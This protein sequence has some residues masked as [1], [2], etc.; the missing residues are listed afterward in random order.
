[1]HFRSMTLNR[2]LLL[3]LTVLII[4]LAQFSAFPKVTVSRN[5]YRDWKAY[6]GGWENIHYSILDQIDRNN[7]HK[8]EVAWTFDTGDAFQGSEMQCNPIVV[9]GTLFATTPKLRVIALDAATGKLRWS[10]NPNEGSEVK[11][12][13][14]NRGLTYW[15][16]DDDQ[17]IYF[18][19][20]QFLYALNARQAI[21]FR[22]LEIQAESI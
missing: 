1:M 11:S 20:K 18:V 13:R 5:R 2:D 14:R 10:F 6:G 12:L 4:L 21:R 9:N 16:D 15:E 7:V 17:R 3:V 8:L 22:L 19:A